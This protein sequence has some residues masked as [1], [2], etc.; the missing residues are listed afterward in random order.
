MTT[1]RSVRSRIAVALA[2]GAVCGVLSFLLTI[3]A[4]SAAV[5]S[6]DFWPWWGTA[7]ALLDHRDP[8]TTVCRAA[9]HVC[10][11]YPITVG[12]VGLPFVWMPLHV[13]GPAF[14]GVSCSLLAFVMTRISWTP[15]LV[16]LSGSMLLT[17]VAAQSSP[18][19]AA[20]V[21]APW[22]TWV[23][24][25]KPNIG[26]AMLAYRPS[27]KTIGIM[28]LIT[29]VSVVTY[30]WWPRE[31]IA[32]VRQSPHYLPAWRTPGGIILMLSVVRWRRPEARLLFAMSVLPTSPIVYEA[33]P[34]AAIATTKREYLIFALGTN[35][36]WSF[37]IG[38]SIQQPDFFAWSRPS[39]LWLVYVP[40]L[41]MVLRR[42]N[43]GA[44]PELLERWV[45]RLPAGIR[46]ARSPELANG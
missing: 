42:P 3:P 28:A 45:A 35:V 2:I 25:F 26:L 1:T 31:W 20:G 37:T 36:A 27:W 5:E 40:L 12:L 19:F 22:L 29:G 44:L 14:V 16:F 4:S 11:V 30:P 23:G 46:G 34:L 17:I 8:Y 9:L 38:R 13:A 15:L 21:F 24:V 6:Q 39:L 7:L 18:L 43:V 41:L 32:A 10:T 33:L